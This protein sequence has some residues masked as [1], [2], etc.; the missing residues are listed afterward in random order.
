MEGDD[1]VDA[2][3][4]LV[5]GVPDVFD[6]EMEDDVEIWRAASRVALVV[7]VYGSVDDGQV[8]GDFENGLTAGCPD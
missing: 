4:L 2:G 8:P 1:G 5:V 7:G 3:E 6:V